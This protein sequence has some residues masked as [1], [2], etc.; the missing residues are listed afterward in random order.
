MKPY[1]DIFANAVKGS[2]IVVEKNKEVSQDYLSDK[3]TGDTYSFKPTQQEI[4]KTLNTL[5]DTLE[6]VQL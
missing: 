6:K 2:K 5:A 3:F 1:M 4:E